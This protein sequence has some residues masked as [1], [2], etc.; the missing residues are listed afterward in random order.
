MF[1]VEALN[2]DPE[3]GSRSGLPGWGQS[4]QGSQTSQTANRRPGC[5]EVPT[6]AE[7][8]WGA[9]SLVA[10]GPPGQA[11]SLAEG[12]QSCALPGNVQSPL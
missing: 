6:L 11:G 9:T 2:P 3:E 4:G 8:R 12:S 5:A 1:G 10:V 7:G